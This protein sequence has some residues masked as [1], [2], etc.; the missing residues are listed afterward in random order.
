MDV[1]S[2]HENLPCQ[3]RIYG[4]LRKQ[5]SQKSDRRLIVGILKLRYNHTTIG[6]IEIHIAGCQSLPDF[7]FLLPRLKFISQKVFL[8]DTDRCL[9]NRQPV[10]LNRPAHRIRLPT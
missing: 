6:N 2:T 8:M 9:G 3:N 1:P 10:N 4:P 5:L 7:P